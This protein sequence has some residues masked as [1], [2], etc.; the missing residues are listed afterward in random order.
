MPTNTKSL[1]L[2]KLSLSKNGKALSGVFIF[3]ILFSEG[4]AQSLKRQCIASTGSF[5]SENGTTVQQTIGQPYGTTSY[6]SSK[7]RFNPGFQQGVFRVE[8]I[9]STISAKIFPNPA[10]NQITIETSSILEDVLLRIVDVSGKL[11]FNEKLNELKSYTI[12]CYNWS[13]GVYVISLSDSQNALYSA[14][15]II[16]R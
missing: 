14:K 9:K 16:S 12:D 5:I 2:Q 7:I 10:S 15:L 4:Q 6:Y 1:F 13:N 8:T 3:F 11:V